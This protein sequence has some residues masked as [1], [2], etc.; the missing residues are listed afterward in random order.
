[1]NEHRTEFDILR[2]FAIVLVIYHHTVTNGFFYFSKFFNPDARSLSPWYSS[3][4]MVPSII[5]IIAVPLFFMISGALLLGKEE[6]ISTVWK[7]RIV[8]YFIVLLVIS[9]YYYFPSFLFEPSEAGVGDFLVKVYSQGVNTHLWFLYFYISYL[10]ILPFLRYIAKSMT[11]N[12]LYYLFGLSVVFNGIIPIVQYCVFED[13]IVMNPALSVGS[14]LSSVVL[15]PLLGYGFTKYKVSFRGGLGFLLGGLFSVIPVVFMT[16]YLVSKTGVCDYYHENDV[17]V[18]W[19]CFGELRVVG[20]FVCV[21]AWVSSHKFS[22]IGKRILAE[23]GSCVFGIYLFE[24]IVR[25]LI[26]EYYYAICPCPD[27][28]FVVWVLVLCIFVVTASIVYLLRKI[29]IIKRFI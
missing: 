26:T 6:S 18:F 4:F 24:S 21:C 14:F 1:M 9:A 20:A 25:E 17:I 8:K 3:F 11:R 28:Y 15:Y 22:E 19:N 7:K 16:V 12:S 2:I 23:I 27:N 13:R 10:V 5:C 29:P